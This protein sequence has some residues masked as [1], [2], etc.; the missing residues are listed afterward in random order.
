M[1]LCSLQTQIHGDAGGIGAIK[2]IA[3]YQIRW[4]LRCFSH[5][6]TQP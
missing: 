2:K 4:C 5:D 3:I 6:A 1:T